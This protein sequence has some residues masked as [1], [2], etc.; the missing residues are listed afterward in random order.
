MRINTVPEGFLKKLVNCIQQAE[1]RKGDRPF[2]T[3]ATNIR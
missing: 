1:C 3:V 2:I